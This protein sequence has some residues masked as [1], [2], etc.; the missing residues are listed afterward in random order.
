MSTSGLDGAF[1]RAA[2][3][4]GSGA[5]K[6]VIADVRGM[7]LAR[8]VYSQEVP[9]GFA[10]DWKKS[11]DGTLSDGIQAKGLE[12]LRRFLE[13]CEE[14]NVP[15][16]SRC[17][18]A[19]EVFRRAEN[20]IAYLERVFSELG[21]PVEVVSQASEAQLGFSTAVALQDGPAEA[22]ICWDS[23]GASFQITSQYGEHGALRSYLGAIGTGIATAWLVE[24]VQGHSFADRHTPNPVGAEEAEMLV[25]KMQR[26]LA[27]PADWLRGRSV[28]AIG[29]PNSM[30]CVV[31]ECLGDTAA[32]AAADVRRALHGATGL[33]DE[34]MASR[35]YCQGELREPPSLIVPKLCLLLAVMEHCAIAE[36]RFCPAIGSCPGLLISSGRF[37]S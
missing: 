31:C 7:S 27:E 16:A 1:R 3:D 14:H 25:K 23:G 34:E 4:I 18:V 15:A 28:T 37:K 6:L 12:V 9:V 35:P 11:S 5:T 10:L 24:E 22:V 32:F 33:T 13:V 2:F 21:L 19:T 29:G 8:V 20:G 30:F 36:V 26:E 17:A